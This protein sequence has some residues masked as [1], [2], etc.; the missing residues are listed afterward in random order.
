MAQHPRDTSKTIQERIATTHVRD[1]DVDID[2]MA[3]ISNVFRVS[4]LFR[5]QAEKHLLD[6]HKLSF[7][8]FTVL[9][10][11]WVFGKMET[12]QLAE[13][14]G[15]AKGTLTGIVSTLEK[16]EFAL[17]VPHLKDGRRKLVELTHKGNQI[18]K[19]LFWQINQ[20]EQAFVSEL[21]KDEIHDLSRLLRIVLHTPE[22][23]PENLSK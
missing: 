23:H 4:V 17:R 21:K 19:A 2:A 7:S 13:E 3:A 10:V 20:L 14:C 1:L 22:H 16:Y 9:W 5:N 12:Y 11:L 8:G 18:M 6:H 15:I